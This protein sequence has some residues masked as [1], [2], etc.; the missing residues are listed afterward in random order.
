MKLSP[1]HIFTLLERYAARQ[2]TEAELR[3]LTAWLAEGGEEEQA[4]FHQFMMQWIEG[5]AFHETH[6]QWDRLRT[7]INQ[8]RPIY[9]DQPAQAPV[10]RLFTRW[11]AAAAVLLLVAMGWY[12]AS[13]YR[14][15][16]RVSPATTI[17]VIAP[18]KQGAILTLADNSQVSLDTIQNSVVALQGG[19]TARVLNGALVYEGKG[20]EIVYNTMS[21]PKGRQFQLTLPDGSKVWLNAASSIRYPVLF[22]SNERKVSITGE[23]YFEVAKGTTPF[24]VGADGRADI[25]VLGTAFN[26]NSYANEQSLDVTLVNGAVVVA[27]GQQN[28]QLKPGQQAQVTSDL[29]F[30]KDVDID[31][32]VA[33]KNGIFNFEDMQLDQVMRQLE[34]WYDIE[35]V[36]EGAVPNIVFEGK[37]SKGMSLQE[38]L[39]T[40][41]L[42][43][44]K[45]RLDPGRKLVVLP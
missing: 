18:G 32:V 29:Q 22:A 40:L 34:R 41:K 25:K 19:V 16:N 21:T 39:E 27:H 7:A 36:Y 38:L 20:S 4:L 31:K 43:N 2:A 15:T 14:T 28:L 12:W 13:N 24:I 6:G 8:G 5:Q 10:R 3:E 35:V 30:K 1:E 9:V 23:A 45:Y 26:V 33:W 42:S 11:V 17:A 37:I 44:V